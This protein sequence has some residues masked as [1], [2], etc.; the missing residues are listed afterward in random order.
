MNSSTEDLT[1]T[2]LNITR[3]G[4]S[5]IVTEADLVAT[6]EPLEIILA[7]QQEG[8]TVQK[9]ISV[10]MR[11]PGNDAALAA[12]F[13]FTEAIVKNASHIK[14]ISSS[15]FNANKILVTLQDGVSPACNRLNGIFIPAPAVV[16]AAKQVLML[17]KL[18]QHFNI[19]KRIQPL[20][21]KTYIAYLNC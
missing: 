10:T 6:E 5:G 13:L 16:Y 8:K 12:G 14:E 11:T 21:P 19:L 20:P 1:I 3:C 4:P 15:S 17:L 2:S 18:S 7:W 9:N